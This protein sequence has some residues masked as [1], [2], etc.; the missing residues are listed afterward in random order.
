MKIASCIESQMIKVTEKE[1]STV[2][3][4]YVILSW[5]ILMISDSFGLSKAR[6]ILVVKK[7]RK[8]KTEER[9]DKFVC[10]FTNSFLGFPREKEAIPLWKKLVDICQHSSC[11]TN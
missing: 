10:V 1:F 3:S 5:N 8:R 7:K 2:I 9:I 11:K 6:E 4:V